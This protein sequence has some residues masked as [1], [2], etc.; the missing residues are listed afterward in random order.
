MGRQNPFFTVVIAT[1][2]RADLLGRA[3]QS[4]ADQLER[5][6]E[7]VVVNDGST[8]DTEQVIQESTLQWGEKLR[9]VFQENKGVAHAKN[10]GIQ[11][12]RGKYIT[13]LD[14]DDEFHPT[15]LRSRKNI[16]EAFP[17]IEFLYGGVRVI[18]NQ[19]VPDR[20]HPGKLIHLSKCTIGGA[21]FIKKEFIKKLGGF[22][23]LPIGT[24]S[25]LLQRAIQTGVRGL[26]TNL[27]TY[28]YRRESKD[29]ITF[30]F[31]RQSQQ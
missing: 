29:S 25:D 16:L 7:V 18:G 28:I 30:D 15:H 14:S 24:D 31:E 17:D 8:D 27:P 6:W 19:Y 11:A 1:Y 21:F 20:F 3:L 12:A 26:E 5:N 10:T 9:Y 4:L 23:P 2:N 22:L 13:F